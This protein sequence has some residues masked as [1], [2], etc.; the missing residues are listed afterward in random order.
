MTVN[1][2]QIEYA[3]IATLTENSRSARRHSKQKIAQLADSIRRLG[4]NVPL[5]VDAAVKPEQ[6]TLIHQAGVRLIVAGEP[7][8]F[9]S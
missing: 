6:R 9:R 7:E 1:S 5:I 8:E 3:P 2:L 4:F